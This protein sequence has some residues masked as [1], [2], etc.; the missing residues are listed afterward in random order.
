MPDM[1]A[2]DGD[3]PRSLPLH[4]RKANLA[5]LLMRRSDGIHLAP[6]EQGWVRLLREQI[7]TGRCDPDLLVFP[8]VKPCDP[9]RRSSGFFSRAAASSW[10]GFLCLQRHVALAARV[11][12]RP[13]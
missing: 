6:F 7:G 13:L 3:D 2:L 11:E 5:R 12:Y 9:G 10:S 8:R 4:L 1:L